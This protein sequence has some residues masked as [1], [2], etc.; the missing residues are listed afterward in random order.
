MAGSTMRHSD[1]KAQIRTISEFAI[2]PDYNA[3]THNNDIAVLYFLTPV[4]WGDFVQ[5]VIL[6]QPDMQIPFGQTANMTG[7]GQTQPNNTNTY[8]KRLMVV[9]TSLV[10]HESC[11]VI[12]EG[13]ITNEM[14]CAGSAVGIRDPCFGD[15]G[16]PLVRNGV[17]LGVMSWGNGCGQSGFPRVYV[18]VPKFDSWIRDNL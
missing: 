15:G 8:S 10:T 13:R 17:Q 18:N 16:G 5:K 4:R 6:P 7:W 1:P 12:Y 9:E 14:L 2:H 3:D 11:N